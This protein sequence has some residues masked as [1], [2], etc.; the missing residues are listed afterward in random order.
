MRTLVNSEF[1][2]SYFHIEPVDPSHRKT[3]NTHIKLA[4]HAQ[5]WDPA[6]V[7]VAIQLVA[8]S[9][10]NIRS[11]LLMLHGEPGSR[12]SFVR[13]RDEGSPLRTPVAIAAKRYGPAVRDCHRRQGDPAT[14]SRRTE[15]NAA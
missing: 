4:E 12:V 7:T 1:G 11:F 9:I 2:S 14:Q 13:P 10:N 6:G 8:M 5:N 3:D 15:A